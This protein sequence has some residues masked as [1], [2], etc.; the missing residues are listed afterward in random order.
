MLHTAA[1][2]ENFFHMSE[3]IN[4]GKLALAAMAKARP[5]M[6]ATFWP[7]NAMA[8]SIAVMPRPTVAILATLTSSF[9]LDC[10]RRI[11]PTYR[12]WESADAPAR[13]EAGHH[14]KDGLRTRP[15]PGIEEHGAAQGLCQERTGHIAALVNGH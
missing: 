5:T 13:V 10:P 2:V 12:S 6:K 3:R 7:L 9:S 1:C 11:T 8:S 14:S 15:P 4:A